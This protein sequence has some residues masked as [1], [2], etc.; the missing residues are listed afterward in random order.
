MVYFDSL[1]S[2]D[3][4]HWRSPFADFWLCI[5]DIIVGVQFGYSTRR[6]FFDNPRSV[7]S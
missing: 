5:K 3:I 1:K 2:L 6:Q 4:N 7:W